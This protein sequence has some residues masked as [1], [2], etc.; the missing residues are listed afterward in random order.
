MTPRYTGVV[1]MDAARAIGCRGGIPWKLAED[2]RLFK[3]ITMGHPILMGRKTWESLGR[4]LPGRQNIVLTRDADYRAE[5]AVVVHDVAALE[6]LELQHE[7]VMVIGG[8]Q[9]Y[10]LLL[11]RME[12]L[13]VSEVQGV[14][15]ADTFF[16]DFNGFFVKRCEIERYEGFVYVEY[17]R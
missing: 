15:E 5:G 13:C 8:A 3:R 9:V 1:A 7:E 4:P 2:M 14:H 12:K 10:E 11:P 6:A 16:P 17:T